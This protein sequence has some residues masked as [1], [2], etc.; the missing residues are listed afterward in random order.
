MESGQDI[1]NDLL[2]T[3]EK[4]LSFTDAGINRA[5]DVFKEKVLANFTMGGASN[6]EKEWSEVRKWIRMK[7]EIYRGNGYS[8]IYT[9]DAAAVEVAKMVLG[10][11]VQ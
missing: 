11:G 9:L 4:L 2:R 1:R 10:K 5:I 8:W 6:N 7:S 3:I